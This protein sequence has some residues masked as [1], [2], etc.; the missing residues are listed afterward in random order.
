M[1]PL[2]T[3]QKANTFEL[4]PLSLPVSFFKVLPLS[5]KI[6]RFRRFRF[7][8]PLPLPWYNHKERVLTIDQFF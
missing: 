7:Q 3:S 4:L 2:P 6:N 1:L 5:Q 8:L